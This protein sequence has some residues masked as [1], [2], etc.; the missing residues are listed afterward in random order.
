M[1][2]NWQS[3][4]PS[5]DAYWMGKVLYDIHHQSGD[6]KRYLEDPAAYLAPFPL[7]DELKAAIRENNIGR[8][9]SVGVNPYLLR[10]HCI[11][12]RIPEDVF[13]ASL[14]AVGK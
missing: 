6:L 8:M 9:Y 3:T 1:S 13:T 5:P 2:G 12:L 14:A 10:A 7:S 4:M 11:G